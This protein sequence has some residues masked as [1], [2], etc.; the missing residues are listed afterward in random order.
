MISN[1]IKFLTGREYTLSLKDLRYLVS[2]AGGSAI[3]G[4]LLYG[5]RRGRLV[6][7]GRGVV[8]IAKSQ[9]HLA[10]GA[11]IGH[12]SYLDASSHRGVKIAHGATLREFCWVQCRSGL[13]EMGEGL[14]IGERAY[15][16]PHASIGVGGMVRIG[17]GTQIGAGLRLS[18]EQH[19]LGNDGSFTDGTTER[20]GITI[21][22]NVWIGNNVT[23]L[24]GVVIG[25][26]AVIGAGAV[27]TRSIAAGM[28]ATGV[29]ARETRTITPP[30]TDGG[31]S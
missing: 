18:A 19:S 12:H 11:A 22:E 20:V 25:D 6:F 4:L 5:I 3:R 1:I 15:I 21:G 13:G 28:V 31:S 27:V 2:K 30:R 29:P 16:G 24:D 7:L 26:K 10:P 8:L 17:A 9:I 14:E 23:I